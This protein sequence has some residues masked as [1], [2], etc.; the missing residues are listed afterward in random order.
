MSLAAP[1]RRRKVVMPLRQLP[2]ARA[3][4]STKISMVG[5]LALIFVMPFFAQV[6][7]YL[8]ELPPPY[9]LSKAWPF[10]MFPF[11]LYAAIR[12]RLPGR[13]MFL[14]LLAYLLG[15]TPLISIIQLGN[16]L[17][18]AM[19]TTVKAWPF[20]Y[21]FAF[22]AVLSLLGLPPERVRAVCLAY[23][24]A[25]FVLLVL[26][27]GLAPRSWYV[28]DPI[29]GKLLQYDTDRGRRVYMSMFF[30]MIFIFY[31]GRSFVLEH[32]RFRLFAIPICLLI[33]VLTYKQRTAI[34]VAVLVSAYGIVMSMPG[35]MRRLAIG[36]GL[37]MLVPM[38]VLVAAKLGL[39]GGSGWDSVEQSLGGSLSVRQNSSALAV[40]FLGDHTLR[41]IFGVGATTRFG[42]VT[43]ADIF[44]YSQFFVSDLGWLGVV[45]EYGLVG[46]ILVLVVH[47]WAYVA[48][49]RRGMALRDPFVLALS[50]YVLYLLLTSAVY[51]LVLQ[52][53]ELGAALALAFYMSAAAR[54]PDPPP[55]LT[56][57]RRTR[58]WVRR[59]KPIT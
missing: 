11:S 12:L 22:A 55:T 27:Y 41:W 50:D 46:A 59:T 56:P 5:T 19:A 10:L 28:T 40:R 31:L 6:F 47:V 21:Y 33:Q 42:S 37:A 3:S 15:F 51:S 49:A 25:T 45:F 34:A 8:N 26:L 48:I 57:M 29:N 35:R 13:N 32:K 44:G 39:F 54:L 18:D 53:G 38:L 23:G 52:P 16:G 36:V 58:S 30:G 17:L 43:L 9:F 1:T 14:L 20:T 7:H 24:V 2:R 4:R